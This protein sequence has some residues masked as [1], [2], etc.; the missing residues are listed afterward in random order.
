MTKETIL[1][2][3]QNE[4]GNVNK[5]IKKTNPYKLDRSK[6]QYQSAFNLL[7]YSKIFSGNNEYIFNSHTKSILLS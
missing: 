4:Q 7:Y 3:H 1:I 6:F 5:K 2:N